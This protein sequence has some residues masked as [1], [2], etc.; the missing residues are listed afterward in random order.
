MKPTLVNTSDYGI[1]GIN[2]YWTRAERF[3]ITTEELN[4]VGVFD[5]HAYVSET[6]IAPLQVANEQFKTLGYELIVKD[7]YRSPELYHL[8]KAKRDILHGEEITSAL[9]NMIKMPHSTGHT[10]DINLIDLN[11]DEEVKMRNPEE[12]PQA[13]FID[14]Y[15]ERTEKKCIEDQRL[16][17][18]LI[19]GMLSAGFELGG[20]KE[21]WH[22]EYPH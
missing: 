1:K 8:I 3:N 17:D 16:Q 11:T 10:V 18:I 6:I 21:F 13:F 20:K 22:F 14:F 2:F 4:E 15:R 5:E 9:L 12:D 7:A 19:G